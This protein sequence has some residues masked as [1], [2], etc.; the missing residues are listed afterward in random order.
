MINHIA[1]RYIFNWFVVSGQMSDPSRVPWICTYCQYSQAFCTLHSSLL[2]IS[3]Y[4]LPCEEY[5]H[6]FEIK[7]P[8][9]AA[10]Y[11]HIQILCYFSKNA[12]NKM[13]KFN[14]G[15]MSSRTQIT[16]NLWG[17]LN[18]SLRSAFSR[19]V[20]TICSCNNTKNLRIL[21]T[22]LIICFVWFS[23]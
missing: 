22:E 1:W 2:L 21:S 20:T 16:D 6:S 13:W 14:R 23:E 4:V 3:Q 9:W 5:E 10:H 15:Y 17:I 12:S 7:Y 8:M 11:S 18:F 19:P